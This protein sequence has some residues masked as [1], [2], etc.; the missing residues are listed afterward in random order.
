MKPMLAHHY[1][2]QRA[3]FPCIGQPKLNGVRAMWL[4]T[5]L[6]SRGRPDEPGIEWHPG[7]LPHIFTA[8]KR[9]TEL[10]GQL[11]YLDGELYCHGK[12]LQEIN[13]RV[14]VKRVSP[15]S[16]CF[17]IKLNIFDII[18][19]AP[20]SKRMQWLRNMD[21]TV[22]TDP[23][24]RDGIEFVESTYLN[25]PNEAESFYKLQKQLKF[26]GAMYRDPSSPYGMESLCGNKENRWKYLLK[27]KSELDGEGII[28][29]MEKGKAGKQFEHV[30]GAILLELPNGKRFRAGSGVQIQHRALITEIIDE[31]VANRTRVRY[32]YD[33]LSDT[34]L[35]LRAR[36]ECIYDERFA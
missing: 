13:S 18:S 30:M 17:E 6:M 14:A 16:S 10:S 32:L 8:L 21:A 20:F 29:G 2:P 7:V 19:H 26:E 5:Y 23:N 24:I 36:I 4:G 9:L 31:L 22:G 1:T 25:T 35:P 11:L 3:V 15:H 12:S 28:V 34:G 33:E 27:R